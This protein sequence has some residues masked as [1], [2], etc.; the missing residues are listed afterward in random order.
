MHAAINNITSSTIDRVKFFNYAETEGIRHAS[1]ML[2]N[3]GYKDP[4]YPE[5]F[6][7]PFH[8]PIT[9]G[10]K[11]VPHLSLMKRDDFNKLKGDTD[12]RHIA[13]LEFWDEYVSFFCSFDSH[14]EGYATCSMDLDEL[15]KFELPKYFI[16]EMEY[17]Y[18]FKDA[19]ADSPIYCTFG[20]CRTT[21]YVVF[22]EDSTVSLY[23][24]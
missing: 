5:A 21:V 4:Y 15:K 22:N 8:Y 13:D 10:G 19:L 7:E 2:E 14:Y 24:K 23:R 20:D 11:L 1:I 9:V 17:C 3:Y 16:K 6:E 18:K 12:Y